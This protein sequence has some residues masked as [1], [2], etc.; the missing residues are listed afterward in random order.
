MV[1]V[2]DV[3]LS[4]SNTSNACYSPGLGENKPSF[5]VVRAEPFTTSTPFTLMVCAPCVTSFRAAGAAG[6]VN[7]TIVLRGGAVATSV[8]SNPNPQRCSMWP[9]DTMLPL[10]RLATP[11]LEQVLLG[12]PQLCAPFGFWTID[13]SPAILNGFMNLANLLMRS[14]LYEE[15]T[16][17]WYR[18]LSL[19]VYWKNEC[20]SDSW[21]AQEYSVS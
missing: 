10:L 2:C 15:Q 13:D 1:I 11:L 21:D 6:E 16:P 5:K 18:I 17:R 3:A 14:D 7:A 9:G 8:T 20:Q 19:F 12:S 4:W